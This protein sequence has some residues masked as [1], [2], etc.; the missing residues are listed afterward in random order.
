MQLKL[1]HLVSV[2]IYKNLT[3]RFSK[4]WQRS[5]HTQNSLRKGSCFCLS[6]WDFSAWRHIAVCRIWQMFGEEQQASRRFNVPFTSYRKNHITD[7]RPGH[8]GF[9]NFLLKTGQSVTCDDNA[10]R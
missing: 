1:K 10:K 3:N 8:S 4:I 2:A 5:T 7:Y 9:Q 6:K